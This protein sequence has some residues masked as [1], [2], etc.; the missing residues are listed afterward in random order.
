M[1]SAVQKAGSS[2]SPALRRRSRVWPMLVLVLRR[3]S[4]PLTADRS[5]HTVPC[6]SSVIRWKSEPYTQIGAGVQRPTHSSAFRVQS[7]AILSLDVCHCQCTARAD[8]CNW[9][10]LC[11]R[12]V[13]TV[14]MPLCP[15]LKPLCNILKL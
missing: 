14:K 4:A 3:T 9:P 1:K 11:Y 10:Q 13:S 7:A 5:C 8:I 15:P 2:R 12:I 6:V